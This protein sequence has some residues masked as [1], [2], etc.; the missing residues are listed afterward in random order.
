MF[1]LKEI[2]VDMLKTMVT[3]ET[4]GSGDWSSKLNWVCKSR[5]ADFWGVRYIIPSGD[6]VID[7]WG[8]IH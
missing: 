8:V 2:S 4:K 1:P 3:M 6:N 7:A 5:L